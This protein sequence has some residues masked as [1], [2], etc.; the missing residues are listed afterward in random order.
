MIDYAAL[1][2][3]R[4][5][6]AFDAFRGQIDINHWETETH[7]LE[8]IEPTLKDLRAAFETRSVGVRQRQGFLGLRRIRNKI[9]LCLRL[10]LVVFKFADL[11]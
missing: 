1:L 11:F 7:S 8:E 9:L 6:H 2:S 5:R 4:L 10:N 3:Y